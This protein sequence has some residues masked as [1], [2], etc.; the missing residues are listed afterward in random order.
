MAP[1][2]QPAESFVVA[3]QTFFGHVKGHG[4]IK[5]VAGQTILPASHPLVKQAPADYFKP[6]AATA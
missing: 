4:E 6:V 2:K 1:A 5:A 3:T